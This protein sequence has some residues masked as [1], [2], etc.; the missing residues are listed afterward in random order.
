[1]QLDTLTAISPIDGRYAA[2]TAS[3][4]PIFSE[5]GL[6]YHRLLVEVRWLQMLSRHRDIG[7]VPEFPAA[8]DQRLDAIIASGRRTDVDMEQFIRR[9]RAGQHLK[10]MR[11][12]AL[13]RNSVYVNALGSM[14]DDRTMQIASPYRLLKLPSLLLRDRA[15][16]PAATDREARDVAVNPGLDVLLVDDHPVM[17]I[18]GRH[19]LEGIGCRVDSAHDGTSALRQWSDRDYDVIFLDGEMPD[20]D[21]LEVARRIRTQEDK[22]SRPRSYIV[23]IA[24]NAVTCSRERCLKAGMDEYIGKPVT[25]ESFVRVLRHL[26]AQRDSAASDVDDAQTATTLLPEM[27]STDPAREPLKH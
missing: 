9:L 19:M 22:E 11:V 23:G 17:Q 18:A 6:I 24:A 21:G 5:Y 15:A 12:V 27:I 14:K 13:R 10:E 3:L 20:I 16:A 1:M 26:N 2:K 7:E 8:A 25:K 4:R